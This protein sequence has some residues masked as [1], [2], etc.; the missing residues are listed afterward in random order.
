MRRPKVGSRGGLEDLGGGR[1]LGRMYR[2][3][4]LILRFPRTEISLMEAMNVSTYWQE[5]GLGMKLE[6]NKEVHSPWHAGSNCSK[7]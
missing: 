4:L 1:R 2:P 6:A 5:G 7:L 3:K